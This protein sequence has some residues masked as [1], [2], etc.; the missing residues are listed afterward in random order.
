MRPKIKITLVDKKGIVLVIRDI[1]LDKLGI[2]ILIGE[3]FVRLLCI[4]YFRW[5][6]FSVMGKA[7]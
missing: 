7:S 6:I 4:L 5:W 1:R 2:L 3:S